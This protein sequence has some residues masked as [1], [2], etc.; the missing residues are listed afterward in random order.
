M[1]TLEKKRIFYSFLS[2]QWILFVL[3]SVQQFLVCVIQ[4]KQT[5]FKIEEVQ[6]LNENGCVSFLKCG[7]TTRH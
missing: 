5:L 7:E 2:F 6:Q 3:L 1:E 4:K